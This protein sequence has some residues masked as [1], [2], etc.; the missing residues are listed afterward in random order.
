MT[1][2]ATQTTAQLAGQR[3]RE[4]NA[5]Q[6]VVLLAALPTLAGGG[7]MAAAAAGQPIVGPVHWAVQACLLAPT[8]VLTAMAAA[9]TATSRMIT[10]LVVILGATAVGLLIA[11][12]GMYAGAA[13]AFAIWC[14]FVVPGLAEHIA[15]AGTL[16]AGA[17]SAARS[18]WRRLGPSS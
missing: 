18:A 14:L 7:I 16:C 12:A 3:W 4:L 9:R 5:A 2:P 10:G 1:A 15:T 11:G 13:L 6:R 8:A 17:R